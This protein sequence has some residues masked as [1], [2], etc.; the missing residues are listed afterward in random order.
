MNPNHL[1]PV[2]DSSQIPARMTEDQ[3]REFWDTHE[4]TQEL[5]DTVEPAPDDLAAVTDSHA[6]MFVRLSV[7]T[8]R[9]LRAL[10]RQRQTRPTTLLETI[11]EER[12]AEEERRG[13]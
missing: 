9:R 11:L 12:L 8:S 7:G 3:A 4:L 5:L 10:A 6:G 1:I 13:A 2:T